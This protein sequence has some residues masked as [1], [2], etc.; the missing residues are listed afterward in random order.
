M[1]TMKNVNIG[2]IGAGDISV[3][4]AQAIKEI[5]GAE[6][7]GLWNLTGTLAE[8]KC[9]LFNCR[10]YESAEALVTDPGIDAVFILTAL[11][12]HHQYALLA[13]RSGK[14]VY[15]EKPVGATVREIQD[16]KTAAA[17]AG[18][19]CMPG[20]NYIYEPGVTRAKDLLEAGKLGDLVSLY[21]L[22][23][24]QHP[25]EVAARF[26]GVIR[27]ILT[28]HA[29]IT[30]YL[31]G[32]PVKVSAMKSTIHYEQIAQEDLAMATLKMSNGAL[33]HLC[34]SFAADDHAGDPWTMMIKLIGTKGA[35]RY[36]YRDWVENTPAQV[37]SQTYS[38]YPYTILNADRFFIEQC[39]MAGKEPL[40]TLDDAI[41]AQKMV[42]AVEA[43]I[44]DEQTVALD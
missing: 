42:E 22:Y 28:H 36:S 43:S 26:P 1:N 37:H 15:V 40:S 7:V 17:N 30:L 27:Q 8:E 24:I 2:F 9:K 6:L 11:E 19:I 5:P 18:K 29:Y 41:V 16:M 3:L 25:E 4:H 33:V 10:K 31:A 12:A 23:N 44:K 39:V 32:Q 14:H 34:A 21:V 13:L 20:H 38:A 35:T